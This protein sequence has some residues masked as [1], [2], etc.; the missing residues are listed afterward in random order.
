MTARARD[1]RFFVIGVL[2]LS[3][4]G[5]WISGQLVKEHAGRWSSGEVRVGLFARVCE[6]TQGAVFDCAGAVKGP[7]G[8]IKI[9]IPVPSRDLTIG[10]HTV[11]MPVAFLGLAYFV[12][13]GVWFAF[14]GRPR[15]YG[16]RW[17]RVPLGV[18]L[19]GLAVSLFY[20]GVMAIGSAPWCVWCLAV[21][22]INLLLVLAIW[23]MGAAARPVGS[24]AT[25]AASEWPPEQIVRAT[26]TFRE[27]TT[28]IAFSLIV[29]AGL[30]AYR[31]EHLAFLNGVR[32]LMPYKRVVTD[33]QKDAAFLLRE[34]DAQPQHEIPLRLGE[35][36]GGDHPQLT[37]FTDFECPACYCQ[38]RAV[39]Q[40]IADAFAGNITILVRHFPLSVTC[41]PNLRED[42]HPNACDAAY[43]AEAAR[44][45]GGDGAFR[46]MHD[47]LFKNRKSLGTETYRELASQ[48]GL[49]VNRF[50]LDMN[51]ERVRAIVE[52]DIRLA[53]ELG[54]TGTPSMFLNGR[55]IPKL[56]RVPTFWEAFAEKWTH[57]AQHRVGADSG[58]HDVLVSLDAVPN[59]K[60]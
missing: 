39:Q 60:K 28:A 40:Q 5:A 49:D 44:L 16:F 13:V 6:A 27:A 50:V 43:A 14:I 11:H 15:I 12:F 25:V 33:L 41:N 51:G 36:S 47:L 58:N 22:A 46:K 32:S 2:A 4:A 57:S 52:S 26:I 53:K 38:S 9:P 59:P 18:G 35:A 21:H 56:C 20:L 34:Y 54:V 24:T 42:H 37:V 30:W 3:C 31:R 17:H 55:R 1:S 8:M 10:V 23:R 48:I 19:C 29:I 7:W 45:Q